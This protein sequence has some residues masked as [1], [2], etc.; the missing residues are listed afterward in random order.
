MACNKCCSRNVNIYKSATPVYATLIW[1]PPNT[2]K[3]GAVILERGLAFRE[4][5]LQRLAS[6]LHVALAF[7]IWCSYLLLRLS[8][9]IITIIISSSYVYVCVCVLVIVL[10]MYSL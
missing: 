6:V 4:V 10:L 7:S 2:I 5:V 1:L 9:I 3:E 8:F